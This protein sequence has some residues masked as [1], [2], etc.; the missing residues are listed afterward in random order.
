MEMFT[1]NISLGIVT[2]INGTK[3]GFIGSFIISMNWLHPSLLYLESTK[4]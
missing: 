2:G 4:Q 1:I 3:H